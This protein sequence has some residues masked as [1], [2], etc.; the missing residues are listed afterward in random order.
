MRKR[1][2]LP[3]FALWSMTLL[4]SGNV[5]ALPLFIEHDFTDLDYMEQ[6]SKFRSGA[7]HDYSYPD[8][9]DPT[10]T[11]RSMKHYFQPYP[12]YRGTDLAVPVYAPFTGTITLV[13]TE[14]LS[15]GENRGK[16]IWLTPEGYGYGDSDTWEVRIFSV[17]LDE[18]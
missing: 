15:E 2:L 7:G 8:D 13:S 5:L 1:L 9:T 12:I 3:L 14:G 11:N 16:Q 18:G 6:V 4:A 10:E 17:N